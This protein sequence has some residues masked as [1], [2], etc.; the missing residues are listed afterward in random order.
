MC[1][2]GLSK[3]TER[4]TMCNDL[5]PVNTSRGKQGECA[6]HYVWVGVGASDGQFFA[7]DVIR[8]HVNPGLWRGYA[9]PHDSSTRS[10]RIQRCLHR[11]DP[12][13]TLEHNVC[14]LLRDRIRLYRLR[15]D[16]FGSDPTVLV[17]FAY[18]YFRST[19]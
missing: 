11:F 3:L 2:P 5:P 8:L 12:A 15:P 10:R 17:R 19:A 9:Y 1:F 13:H 16:C 4:K 18:Y 6:V 7:E 14:H